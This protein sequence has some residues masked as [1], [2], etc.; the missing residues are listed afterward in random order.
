M[1]ARQGSVLPLGFGLVIAG[2]IMFEK[3]WPLLK[4]AFSGAGSTSSTPAASGPLTAIKPTASGS[5]SQAQWL[6]VANSLAK[7]KGWTASEVADWLAI[8][9]QHEDESL[10]LTAKNPTSPAYGLA[11]GI[12]GPSWYYGYG[13]NPNTLLGQLTAMANY[14][15]ERYQTPTAALAHENAYGWY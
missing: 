4:Q 2:G 6:T 3:G 5:V 1:A 15:Q 8:D 9:L 10:S 14:I 12:T 13:G 11:Q 7:S